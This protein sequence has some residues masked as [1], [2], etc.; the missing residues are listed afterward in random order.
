VVF[1][2]VVLDLKGIGVGDPNIPSYLSTIES[3]KGRILEAQWKLA[4]ARRVNP[5]RSDA[6]VAWLNGAIGLPNDWVHPMVTHLR[7]EVTYVRF[8]ER[9]PGHEAT[10]LVEHN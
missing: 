8:F 7:P 1:S 5:L 10:L 3:G 2:P 9:Q 6:F 4:R